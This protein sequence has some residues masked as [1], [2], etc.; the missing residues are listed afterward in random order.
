MYEQDFQKEKK[1]W[2]LSLNEV[3]YERDYSRVAHSPKTPTNK[4]HYLQQT[5]LPQL[6]DEKSSLFHVSMFIALTFFIDVQ[7]LGFNSDI[8][9]IFLSPPCFVYI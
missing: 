3:S 1:K 5:F 4:I 8:F 6:V 9:L 2:T 7:L